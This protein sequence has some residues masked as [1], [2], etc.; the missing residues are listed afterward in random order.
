MEL[1][2]VKEAATKLKTNPHMVYALIKSKH[3]VALKLGRIK[4]PDYELERFVK[5]SQGMDLT[6]PENVKDLDGSR[7]SNQR[8][9]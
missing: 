6:D 7:L 3:I 2:T 5:E 9:P 8:E 1:Y 4:I